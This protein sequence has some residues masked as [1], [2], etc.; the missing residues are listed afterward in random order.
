M[1][2]EL[3]PLQ[4]RAAAVVLLFGLLLLA[5]L[6]LVRPLLASYRE[7]QARIEL[8]EQRLATYRHEAAQAP[9]IR[10]QLERARHGLDQAGYFLKANTTSLASAELQEL[11]RDR[12]GAAGGHLLSSQA[13]EA[14]LDGGRQRASV[15][16]RMQGDIDSLRRVLFALA[17]SRPM[18]FVDELVVTAIRGRVVGRIRQGKDNNKKQVLD[19]RIKASAYMKTEPAGA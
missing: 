17:S 9:A 1:N 10:A 16:A 6:L 14:A 4:R 7:N 15:D 5:Y 2:I 19:I 18:I 12:I 13:H 8:L 3:T 11:V